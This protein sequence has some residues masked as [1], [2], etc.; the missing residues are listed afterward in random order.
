MFSKAPR[1]RRL[2][3]W[4]FA[5]ITTVYSINWFLDGKPTLHSW[6]VPFGRGVKASLYVGVYRCAYG[7]SALR[8][9]ASVVIGDVGMSFSL[10]VM[11][12]CGFVIRRQGV[13]ALQRGHI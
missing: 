9:R 12:L 8:I 2:A 5:Y 3:S 11:S 13:R 10:L 4:A 7:G 1:E 6:S